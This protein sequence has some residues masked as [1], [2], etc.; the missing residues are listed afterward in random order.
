MGNSQ[1]NFWKQ[2]K[3]L[4]ETPLTSTNI[5]YLM[6]KLNDSRFFLLTTDAMSPFFQNQTRLEVINTGRVKKFYNGDV[7]ALRNPL[8]K[9]K[10][11]IRRITASPFEK[12]IS[13][14]GLEELPVPQHSYWVE[15]DNRA[16]KPDSRD[17]GFV[18]K[19]HLM[20]RAIS[21]LDVNLN[22]TH[23]ISNSK[24]AIKEDWNRLNIDRGTI[25]VYC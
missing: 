15:C 14:K 6:N 24:E 22:Y 25:K 10:V 9:S 21:I 4:S 16:E 5:G 13:S 19:E 3:T 7:V 18:K 20:G 12:L 17:F 1:S 23:I 11:L 8:E 2:L